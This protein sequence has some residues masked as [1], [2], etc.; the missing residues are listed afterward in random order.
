M[1]FLWVHHLGW[2]LLVPV[3]ALFLMWRWSARKN[4]LERIG[5]RALIARLSRRVHYGRR[6]YQ[7]VLWLL[8]LALIIIALARPT[9]GQVLERVEVERRQMVVAIDVSRSMD[10]QDIRPSR[11]ERALLD[12]RQLLERLE[13]VDVGLVLFTNEAFQ[14]VPI[15]YDLQAVTLYLRHITTDA[16]TQQGT[17]LG[18]AL[19]IAWTSFDARLE[20]ERVILMLTDGENHEGDPLRMATM[21]GEEG[22]RIHILGY[23]TEA[24]AVIPIYEN[25]QLLDYKTDAQGALVETRA[26]PTMMEAITRASGG[27]LQWVNTPEVGIEPIVDAI[28]GASAGAGEQIVRVPL[29]QFHWFV[30]GALILLTMEMLTQDVRRA[31]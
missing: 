21:I 24:G 8:T 16:I 17:A 15:T 2:L 3:M 18:S 26:N 9:W 4:A 29:E 1:E 23:G 25:G 7:S 20:S 19:D 31:S 11:L 13:G 27:V 28:Q 30:L 14:Y 10:A 5:D 6:I 12:L 22:G